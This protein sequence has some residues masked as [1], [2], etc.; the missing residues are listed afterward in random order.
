MLDLVMST[1]RCFINACKY[2]TDPVLPRQV[3]HNHT[4]HSVAEFSLIIAVSNRLALP[5]QVAVAL[6]PHPLNLWRTRLWTAEQPVIFA[7]CPVIWVICE[8]LKS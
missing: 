2:P 3:E 5:S 4:L 6:L 7:V 8:R 1:Q